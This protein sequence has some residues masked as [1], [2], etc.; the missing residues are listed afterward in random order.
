MNDTVRQKLCDLITQYGHALCDNARRCE[1]LLKDLCGQYKR[2]INILVNALEQRVPIDLLASSDSV[3]KAVILARL[4]K[5]ME[6]D[7]GLSEVAALW[8]VESWALA[9]GVISSKDCATKKAENRGLSEESVNDIEGSAVEDHFVSFYNRL[10]LNC[11]YSL[12]PKTFAE[13]IG[14]RRIKEALRIAVDAAYTRGDAV[15][16]ILFYGPS[17]IGKTTIANIVA[18]ERG[19]PVRTTSGSAIKQPG[20]LAAILTSLEMN[21]VFVIDEIHR[22][23]R[24][25]EEILYPA[26]EDFKLDIIIGKGPSARILRLDLPRFA[27][28]GTT[29]Q[30]NKLSSSLRHCFANEYRLESYSLEDVG[31]FI[32]LYAY[33]HQIEVCADGANEIAQHSHS[34]PKIAYRILQYACDYAQARADGII[35]R[36]VALAAIQMMDIDTLALDA[37]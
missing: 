35:T 14:Q 24:T 17:G 3:P 11:L 18:N 2:E 31:I 21:S 32:H 37:G 12:E 33:S 23:N 29:T 6:D 8:A 22:L 15:R 10:R 36:E 28:I 25:V 27:L 16:H 5:K 30:I 7:L 1:G 13:Y 9:L 20:D 19:V 4:A 26:M 34:K